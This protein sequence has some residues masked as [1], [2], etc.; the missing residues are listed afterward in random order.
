MW[1]RWNQPKSYL[2][3]REPPKQYNMTKLLHPFKCKIPNEKP[4]KIGSGRM[5]SK[6]GAPPC[7][8]AN[9]G[10]SIPEEVWGVKYVRDQIHGTHLHEYVADRLGNVRPVVRVGWDGINWGWGGMGWD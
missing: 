4:F 8:A 2:V 1:L 9:A 10:S 7:D 3:L 5:C 6:K